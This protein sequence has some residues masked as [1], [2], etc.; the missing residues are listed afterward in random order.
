MKRRSLILLIMIALLA[1]G[2]SGMAIGQDS[3]KATGSQSTDDTLKERMKYLGLII[4]EDVK[5]RFE[6]LD[7]QPPPA[8]LNTEDYFDWRIMG[9]VTPVK[10]QGQCGSCWDF[11]ATG[12]FESAVLIEGGIELDLSEQQVLSCNTG[13]SDCGGGWME[14]A[15]NL[16]MSY[17]A[18]DESCMPYEANDNIP[19]T[20]EDCDP[21]AWM[22]GYE[23]IS[24][25]INSIKNAVTI[26]PVSTTFMVYSDFH[27]DCYWHEDT[28]DLNHAVLIVGW[29]DDMCGGQGAW[30]I[31]NSWGTDWGDDG[32]FYMPYGSSGI[33]RYTQR[34]LFGGVAYLTFIYPDGLPDFVDPAGATTVRVEVGSLAGTPQPGTG[35]MYYN[36]GSEWIDIYLD[37]VAP[38]VYDAVFPP[39]ECGIEV[40]YYF[41]AEEIG[42]SIANDPS[43]APD[44]TYSAVSADEIIVLFEDDFETVQGW[45]V[46]NA[47]G[48]TDGAWERAIPAGGGDRGDPPTDYDGSGYCY[49]TDNADGDSDVDDGYTYLIS[50]TFDLSEGEHIFQY[51]LWYTNTYGNDPNNDLFKVWASSNDGASWIHV[52]TFGPVTQSGWTEHS[53]LVSDHI[54]QSSQ[55]KVRFEASDLN[56]GSVVEAGIDAVSVISF[57]CEGTDCV[58]IPGDVNH[59][60]TPLELG[61]VIAMIGI[62]RG[63]EAPYY[64]C[65]CPPWGIFAPGADPNGNCVAAELDDIVREIA[66]YRGTQTVA[67]CGDCPGFL[68]I[69][70]G[71]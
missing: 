13:G 63:T 7:R 25:N 64:N 17:G 22:V 42:G 8:L 20:Q 10:A 26:G 36:A 28:G 31:K 30:I 67:G 59:N 56:D 9:G 48:L 35:M 71:R 32:Y 55:V 70:L 41:S 34:P 45:T 58:Y 14:D 60:G 68:R 65:N 44:E 33:G 49:V 51:A 2:F 50:P 18:V 52:E 29:D 3:G 27:W 38:N 4:P 15:Y 47:G 6:E 69:T 24:N 46:Q 57:D 62:Y 11:A 1:M 61:D 21:L 54:T 40:S 53:F 23:D 16:F 19:C 37:V 12:A 43:N 5:K 39:I 66:A